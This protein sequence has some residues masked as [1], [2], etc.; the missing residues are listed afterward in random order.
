MPLDTSLPEGLQEEFEQKVIDVLAG[1]S[2]REHAVEQRIPDPSRSGDLHLE[3][4]PEL[5]SITVKGFG[6][7]MLV[8]ELEFYLPVQPDVDLRPQDTYL[9]DLGGGYN[10]LSDSLLAT[11]ARYCDASEAEQETVGAGETKAATH[12]ENHVSEELQE[13][14]G[15]LCTEIFAG[16]TAKFVAGVEYP[17]HVGRIYSEG[18]WEEARKFGLPI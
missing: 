14:E 4:A 6:D 2:Q 5:T 13:R 16:D 7:R 15:F 8:V 17:P 11:L 10:A 1:V 18:L 3:L 9:S 12:D